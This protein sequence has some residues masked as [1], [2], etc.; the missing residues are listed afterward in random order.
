VNK[1]KKLIIICFVIL[2]TG[3]GFKPILSNKENTFSISKINLKGEER[4]NYQLA[5]KLESY[6]KLNKNNNVYELSIDTVS[7][8]VITSKDTKGNN[9]T[10]R[11]EISSSVVIQKKGKLILSKIIKKDFGYTSLTNKFELKK[12]EENIKK[13]LVNEIFLDILNLLRSD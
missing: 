6:K 2:I 12:Y 7:N 10:F 5:N 1:L 9:K 13:N 3:C 8:R 4:I 11:Y